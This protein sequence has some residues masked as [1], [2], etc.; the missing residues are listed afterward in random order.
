M[1]ELFYYRHLGDAR[2]KVGSEREF[3]SSPT[4]ATGRQDTASTESLVL[5]MPERPPGPSKI[6]TV[7]GEFSPKKIPSDRWDSALKQLALLYKF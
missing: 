1:S 3:A 7:I 2:V 5:D 6:G 4:L